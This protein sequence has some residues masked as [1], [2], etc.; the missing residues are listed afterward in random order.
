MFW[1]VT[2][3]FTGALARFQGR[4]CPLEFRKPGCGGLVPSRV[5]DASSVPPSQDLRNQGKRPA[6]YHAHEPWT[7]S[8]PTY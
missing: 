4:G 5:L 3:S 2:E 7:R 8:I 1:G 6:Q